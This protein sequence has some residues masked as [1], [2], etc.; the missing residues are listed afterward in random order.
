M[1]IKLKSKLAKTFWRF[2]VPLSPDT[3]TEFEV[4]PEDKVK[5]KDGKLPPIADRIGTVTE[6]E[7]AGIKDACLLTVA[8]G[9][10]LDIDPP[11]VFGA[12]PQSKKA[13][14]KASAALAKAKAKIAAAE[15]KAAA[16]RKPLAPEDDE[17]FEDAEV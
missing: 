5:D 10:A 6:A 4:L 17:E 2:G 14:I 1:K 3:W 12:T 7:L 13:A 11:D 15:A 8:Q 9:G 16:K